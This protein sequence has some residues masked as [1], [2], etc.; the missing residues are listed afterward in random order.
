MPDWT[1]AYLNLAPT[2]F[3]PGYHYSGRTIAPLRP[4]FAEIY[5]KKMVQADQGKEWDPLSACFPAGFPRMMAEGRIFEFIT[6]PHNVWIL[7]EVANETHRIY[8]D[9]RG[10]P[11]DDEAYPKWEGDAVGVWD[12]DT[13]L[14]YT[15]HLMGT[16]DGYQRNGPAQTDDI[17][18]IEQY[19]MISPDTIVLQTTVYDPKVLTKPWRITPRQYKRA[20]QDGK[21]V[22]PDYYG[23][24]TS[25]VTL[26]AD[27]T[28]QI[29]LP[30]E[31]ANAGAPT[32]PR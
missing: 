15:R 21:E 7:Q 24:A 8:T 13:L 19:R 6:T 22:R 1:G 16:N 10:F 3:A 25:P 17:E 28:T 26:N 18:V 12:D 23:C 27:G 2:Q 11:P 14:V 29:I 20:F 30:N 32:A 5:E 4:Q 31:R 9:G